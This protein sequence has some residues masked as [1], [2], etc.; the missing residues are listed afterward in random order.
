[1]RT[2]LTP[3]E[4]IKIKNYKKLQEISIA[5]LKNLQTISTKSKKRK[6]Q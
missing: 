3:D 4:I 5:L 6:I 1:M 2:D